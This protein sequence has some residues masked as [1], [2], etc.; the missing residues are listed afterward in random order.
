MINT[1]VIRFGG[2]LVFRLD[3]IAGLISPGGGDGE[4]SGED[5]ELENET[6]GYIRIMAL[7]LGDNVLRA[8]RRADC[9]ITKLYAHRNVVYLHCGGSCESTG[10]SCAT[11]IVQLA[12]QK[13][14]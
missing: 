11:D 1:H 12:S 6:I 7:S 9:S 4:Q 2:S 10:N 8:L 13:F 5:E 3:V 14:I